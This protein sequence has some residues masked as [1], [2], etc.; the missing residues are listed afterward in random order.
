MPAALAGA[1]S[2]SLLASDP[3]ALRAVYASLMLGLSFFLIATPRPAE[4]A[5]KAEDGCEVDAGREAG[6]E[7]GG[8]S[9]RSEA[10]NATYLLPATGSILAT[11][12]T[13]G[14]GFL[15][16]LL[17]VGVGEVVLPQLVRGCCM[18]LPVAAGTSVATVVLTAAVAAA[19]QFQTLAAATGGDVTS[20]IPWALVQ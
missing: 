10:T 20:V 11:G 15:T 16:G 18:P 5:A 2:A 6:R 8:R 3:T 13:A 7:A 17:G 4:I 1:L 19:I 9:R 14:G 12:L